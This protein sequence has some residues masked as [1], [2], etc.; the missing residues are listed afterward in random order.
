MG[1]DGSEL[2]KLD[3]KGKTVAALLDAFSKYYR[4]NIGLQ[5]KDIMFNSGVMLIDLKRWRGDNIEEKI[6]NFIVE[7][8][9]KVQQG[10]QGVLNAVLSK[11][12][13]CFEPCFNAVTIFFDFSYED[14]CIYRK[15]PVFYGEEQVRKAVEDPVIVHFTTSFMSRRPWME[16]CSHKYGEEWMR[17]RNMSPWRNM[18]LRQDD[19]QDWKRFCSWIYPKIPRGISTRTAGFFQVYVRPLKNRIFC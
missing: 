15:P 9:G 12:V 13:Y 17:Y 5:S 19:R 16:G 2:W 18:S 6:L 4:G 11:D 3:M 1:G 14:M 8:K 10:D 7:K